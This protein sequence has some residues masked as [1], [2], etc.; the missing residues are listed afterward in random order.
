MKIIEFTGVSPKKA[1]LSKKRK[2]WALIGGDSRFFSYKVK[3]K[4][5]IEDK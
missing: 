3:N 4:G 5:V 1:V 2:T